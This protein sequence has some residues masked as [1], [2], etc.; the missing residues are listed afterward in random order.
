M[1]LLEA[2]ELLLAALAGGCVL[3][4]MGVV[5]GGWLVVS[6]VRG[7]LRGEFGW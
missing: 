7:L 4:G 1:K 6:V 3:A 5:T 2:L